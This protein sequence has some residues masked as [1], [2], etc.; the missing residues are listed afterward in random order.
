[1]KALNKKQ[2]LMERFMKSLLKNLVSHKNFNFMVLWAQILFCKSSSVH[3]PCILNI[4]FLIV[5]STCSFEEKI[6]GV[7]GKNVPKYF[8]HIS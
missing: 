5:S 8:P 4:G 3:L 7:P 6:S 1:M 2:K